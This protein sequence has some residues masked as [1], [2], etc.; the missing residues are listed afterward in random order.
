MLYIY[1]RSGEMLLTTPRPDKTMI[2]IVD[3]A[4][5][6]IT[7]AEIEALVLRWANGYS[8]EQIAEITNAVEV[9]L[10]SVLSKAPQWRKADYVVAVMNVSLRIA[11]K[12]M[13]VNAPASN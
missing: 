3:E 2:H 8:E 11:K 12:Y 6:A 7:T 13:S 4:P 1:N 10:D 9:E 5:R